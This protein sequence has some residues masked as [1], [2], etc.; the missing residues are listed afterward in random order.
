[1]GFFYINKIKTVP[2]NIVE[3]LTEVGLAFWNMDDGGLESN[4]T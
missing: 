3:L 4:G 2:L 1:M